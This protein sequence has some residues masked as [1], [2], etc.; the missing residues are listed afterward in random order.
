MVDYAV[1]H[2]VNYF[3]TAYGYHD[4]RSECV[5]GRVLSSVSARAASISPTKFPG[6]DLANMSEG[7][8]DL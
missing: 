3:D 2:G 5:M 8:G 4:G 6:Y 7:G 1:G